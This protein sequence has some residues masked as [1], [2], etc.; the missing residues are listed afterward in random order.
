MK[1]FSTLKL[2]KMCLSTLVNATVQHIQQFNSTHTVVAI[3]TNDLKTNLI[4][5][6]KIQKLCK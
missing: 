3:V 6:S 1:P 4:L 2:L 5:N